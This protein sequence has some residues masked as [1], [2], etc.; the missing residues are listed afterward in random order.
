MGSA[1]D[2]QMFLIVWTA[3]IT[4][5]WAVTIVL[6]YLKM[7]DAE[8]TDKLLLSLLYLIKYF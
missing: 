7:E 3:M 8:P 6:N 1:S 2:A 5:V 4:D